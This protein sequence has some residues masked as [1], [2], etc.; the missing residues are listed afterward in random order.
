MVLLTY[1]GDI[2][3]IKKTENIFCFLKTEHFIYKFSQHQKGHKTLSKLSTTIKTVISDYAGNISGKSIQTLLAN[4]PLAENM[5]KEKLAELNNKRIVFFALPAVIL[6]IA[7]GI[8][9]ALNFKKNE[10]TENIFAL[11]GASLIIIA[12]GICALI[13]NKK[14][15]FPSPVFWA[16]FTAAMLLITAA[17][18]TATAFFVKYY[19]YL[20]IMTLFPLFD[21]KKSL[22]LICP[23]CIGAIIL[24]IVFGGDIFLLIISAIF[25]LAHIVISSLIYSAF[26]CNFIGSRQLDNANERCRR[27]NE[28]DVLTGLLN[29]KGL[30]EKLNEIVKNGTDKNIAAIFFGI[31]DFRQYNHIWG[32][33]ESDES[34]YKICN[35]VRIVAKPKTD[36]ISRY[37]GDEFVIIV[38]N[39]TEYDL[40][41][42]A[43]QIRKSVERMVLPFNQSRMVTVSVGVSSIIEGNIDD[44]SKLLTEA[45]D[46][47][48]L[49]KKGGK[50]CVGYMGNVFK[51]N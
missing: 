26:A 43:E 30:T 41:Y 4:D 45:E 22:F 51:A 16:F 18:F 36:I 21:L 20:T 25:A 37:G 38:Q 48:I 7:F 50:N 27:I 10:I 12:C 17:D 35:C 49:A 11:T 31:D 44:Y 3:I 28:Q 29:K 5:L 2:V 9:T 6:S 34:L 32:D 40:I 24:G 8:F 13:V 46:S 23:Y 15:K 47:L 1:G 19:L 42:F 33:K 14:T 39:I